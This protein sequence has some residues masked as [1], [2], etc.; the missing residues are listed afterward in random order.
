MVIHG[1]FGLLTHV[2]VLLSVAYVVYV[3]A[4]KEKG[5]LHE[6]G[7]TLAW[8][9]VLIAILGGLFGAGRIAHHKHFAY[10]QHDGAMMQDGKGQHMFGRHHLSP[11][12]NASEEAR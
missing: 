10:G 7:K 1:V 4:E 5:V 3:F 11:T 6:I 8:G 9:L 2:L 12:A